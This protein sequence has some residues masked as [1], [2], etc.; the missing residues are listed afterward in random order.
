MQNKIFLDSLSYDYKSKVKIYVR[1]LRQQFK[2]QVEF[3]TKFLLFLKEFLIWD[4]SL[5]IQ[6]FWDCTCSIKVVQII[7][8]FM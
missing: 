6:I 2:E 1:L 4:L 8:I 5:I 7:I 3:K